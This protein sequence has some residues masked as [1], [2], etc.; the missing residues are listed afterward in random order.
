MV[1][2]KYISKESKKIVACTVVQIW[3]KLMVNEQYF[4]KISELS[5]KI[6]E[7]CSKFTDFTKILL[8]NKRIVACMVVIS[9]KIS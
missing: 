9:P 1:I 3:V 4:V 5:P 8:K 7:I 2:L 6:S